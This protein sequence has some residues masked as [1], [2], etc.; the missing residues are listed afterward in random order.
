MELYSDQH[1]DLK[2][3]QSTIIFS[4]RISNLIKA[5]MSRTPQ[6]ALRE[7]SNEYDVSSMHNVSL[8]GQMNRFNWKINIFQGAIMILSFFLFVTRR[9]YQASSNSW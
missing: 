9:Q 7:N 1:Y 8:E 6:D 5:M 3:C 2:D 4:K